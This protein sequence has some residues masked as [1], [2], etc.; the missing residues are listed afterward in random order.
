MERRADNALGMLFKTPEY[1]KVK[2]RL[3]SVIGH[4][5]ALLIYEEMLNA[6]I[7]QL[8]SFYSIAD[9][10]GFY[11][12]REPTDYMSERRIIFCPQE[13]KDLGER[14]FNAINLLFKKGYKKVILIGSDSPDLPAVYIKDAFER[15]N[16]FKLV[17]GPSEDGGYYLIGMTEPME[18]L[19]KN[20]PW[21]SNSVLKNTIEVAIREGIQYSLL[22]VWYDVDDLEGLKK[23]KGS[24]GR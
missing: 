23:W 14:M 11:A 5:K 10:Y 15:L 17:I 21:G 4:E 7:Q 16:F 18:F 19:F 12:G 1:G 22:P 13:G 20:I 2:T 6:S 3:A 8:L 9:L 24:K